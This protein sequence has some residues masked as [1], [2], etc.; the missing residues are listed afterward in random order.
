MSIANPV[1]KLV[2]SVIL[3]LDGT[4]LNTDGIVPDVLRRFLVKY[5]KQWDGREVNRIVGK[6]PLEA[7]TAVVEAYELPCTTEEFVKEFTP[8]FSD[9]WSNIKPLPGANRLIN[10]LHGHGIP[11]ALASNSP[12]SNVEKKISYHQGWKDS[13]A[14]VIG[15]DEVKA[16]KPSPDIFLEAAKRLNIEPSNCLVIEDSM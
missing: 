9:Y 12:R 10:H 14:V 2:S 3:D 4:L 13:F 6:T 1:K 8:M 16:A 15:G 5:G 11:M 7:S